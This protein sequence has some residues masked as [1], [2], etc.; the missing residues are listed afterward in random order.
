MRTGSGRSRGRSRMMRGTMALSRCRGGSDSSA[1]VR[2]GK[3]PASS[4]Y[5]TTPTPQLSASRPSYFTARSTCS[6]KMRSSSLPP[7]F[8]VRRTATGEG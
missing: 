8:Q 1:T 7:A 5:M 2:K 3:A 4:T 6:S